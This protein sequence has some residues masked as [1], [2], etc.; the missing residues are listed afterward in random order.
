MKGRAE[1]IRLILAWAGKEYE[2]FRFS[3]TKWPEIKPTTPFGQVPVVEIDG[4]IYAQSFAIGNYF[5]REFGLYGKSNLDA[6]LIDQFAHLT[7]DFAQDAV[8]AFRESD[9]ENKAEA[10]RKVKEDIAPRYLGYVDKMV[11]ENSGRHILGDI[12]TVADLVFYD[13]AT[14]FLQPY[15]E[16]VLDNFPSL[17][18]LVQEVACNDRIQAYAERQK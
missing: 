14:G 16:D 12:F 9:K 18:Q 10:L 3:F 7:G 5:A 6:L 17:K 13:V 1:V 15:V 11:Q 2:D 8:A 4:Q